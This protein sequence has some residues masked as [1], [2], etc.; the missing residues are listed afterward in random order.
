MLTRLASAAAVPALAVASFLAQQP[1]TFHTEVD[2][3][4]VQVTVRTADGRIAQGLTKSDFELYDNSRRREIMAFAADVQP[5][6]MALMLDRSGSLANQAAKVT[7]AAAAFI[8]ELLPAD[9]AAVNTL[10]YE[11]QPLTSDRDQLVGLLRGR[12]PVDP[13][14]PIWAGLDRTIASIAGELGPRTILLFS[15]GDDQSPLLPGLRNRDA[16]APCRPWPTPSEA[17]FSDALRRAQREGVTIFTVSVEGGAG[18]VRNDDL[19]MMARDSGGER[20]RL[21][22]DRELAAA[23]TRIADTLHHEYLL[24]FVPA[25]FDGKV[26][27]LDVRVRRPGVTVSA[28][29]SYL[30]ERVDAGPSR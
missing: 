29:R 21:K 10:N 17:T 26:H 2:T 7:A 11:C 8:R 3:V 27:D 16:N 12:M 25:A 30:A 5:I 18:H 4:E 6:T 9:R 13:G 15:D 23:F 22:D 20:Y 1:A 24:G 19:K 14:S 28:R